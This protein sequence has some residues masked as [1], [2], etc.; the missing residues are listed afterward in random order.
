MTDK[1]NKVNSIIEKVTTFIFV[2]PFCTFCLTPLFVLCGIDVKLMLSI[3]GYMLLVF[4]GWMFIS[5]F[6]R[7]FNKAI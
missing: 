6:I 1:Q 4:I 3:V 5:F 7:L 2:F